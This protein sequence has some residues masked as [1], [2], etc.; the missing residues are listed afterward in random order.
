MVNRAVKYGTA[1]VLAHFVVNIIHGAAHHEL[2]VELD[3]A[4]MLFVIGVILLCPLIAMV[5]LWASQESL[6]QVLMAFSMAASLVFGLYKHFVIMGPDNIREQA[7]G[8]WGTEFVL[9]AYLLCL[10]EAIGTFMGLYFL[11]RRIRASKAAG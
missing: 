7:P 3:R 11:H 10:T 5:L 4:A 2:H 8:P 1:V 9:T 6:G